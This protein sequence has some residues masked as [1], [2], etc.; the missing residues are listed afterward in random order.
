MSQKCVEV[1]IGRL[2]TDETLRTLFLADPARTLDSLRE[3]GVD[4]NPGEIA[5]LLEMPLEAWPAMADWVHPRLQKI[6]M[7]GDR[8]EP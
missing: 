7:A 5:A 8:H 6:A 3:A 4:L 2:A 1:V